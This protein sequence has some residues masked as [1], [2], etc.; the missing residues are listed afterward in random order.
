MF[1][2]LLDLSCCECDVISL[3]VS[4]LRDMFVLCVACLTVFV[5]CLV[6]QFAMCL[7]VVVI[8]L[9]NV[10]EVFSVGESMC[11]SKCSFHMFSLC[12]CLS[13]VISSFKN[14]RARTLCCLFV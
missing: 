4:L 12:F 2:C 14:L 9:L 3:C 7:G 13:D 8:L 5:N 1:Y 10:M 6:K 11:A